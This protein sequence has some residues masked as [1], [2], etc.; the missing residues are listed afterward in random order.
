MAYRYYYFVSYQFQTVN[1]QQGFGQI[2]ISSPER[3][4]K[5]EDI[6]KFNTCIREKLDGRGIKNPVVIIIFYQFLRKEKQVL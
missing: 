1:G 4:T 6:E 3:V 5:I 2:D